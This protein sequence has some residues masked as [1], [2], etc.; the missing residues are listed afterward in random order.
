MT[1]RTLAVS[2][3]LGVS[4]T[5]APV[6]AHAQAPASAQALPAPD[7]PL[8]AADLEGLREELRSSRKQIMAA[9]L[10]L[11][12]AEATRFWPVYD[13]YAAERTTIK[14]TQYA[15]LAEYVNTYGKYDDK[16]ALDFITRWLDQ[17][18]R[19]ET[20]RAKYVPTVG[21]VLPGV[22][23]ATFFQIDRRLSMAID[24][25]LASMLPILVTQDQASKK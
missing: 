17:D 5:Q 19:L 12:D 15:L 2:L 21:K 9:T 11:T 1:F 3:L 20:L 22:K 8:T 18:V 13:R 7:K 14:D 4:L 25:K 24:L 23:A 16:G 10:T 6:L